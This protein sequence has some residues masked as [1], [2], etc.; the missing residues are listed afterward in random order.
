MEVRLGVDIGGTFTDVVLESPKGLTS[1][2]VLTTY[3]APENAIIEGFHT[4]GCLISLDLCNLHPN[5]NLVTGILQPPDQSAL[6]H[7]VAQFGHFNNRGH[8]VLR[9]LLW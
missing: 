4:H 7:G 9:L 2:K 1:I 6:G 3:A 5:F 8:G